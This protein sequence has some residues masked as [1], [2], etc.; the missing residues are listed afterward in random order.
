MTA[1]EAPPVAGERDLHLLLPPSPRRV[2]VIEGVD[3][4][5]SL[6]LAGHD[7]TSVDTTATWGTGF[8]AVVLVAPSRS[9]RSVPDLLDRAGSAAAGGSLLVVDRPRW[10]WPELLGR[11]RIE[12]R[13]M[14]PIS[15]RR[16]ERHLRRRHG[17]VRCF[18]TTPH[19]DR[20]RHLLEIPSRIDRARRTRLRTLW[21]ALWSDAGLPLRWFAGVLS[22]LPRRAVLGTAPTV[23]WATS[24][25]EP[26]IVDTFGNA[27][28]A[29]LGS[30][31][32]PVV[33][34]L[35]GD[36]GRD[37]SVLSPDPGWAPPAVAGLARE[38]DAL[39]VPDVVVAR[40]EV[41]GDRLVVG[42]LGGREATPA[43]EVR[44]AVA[45]GHIHARLPVTR[46][47]LRACSLA[48]GRIGATALLGP[49]DAELADTIVDR[50][51][52]HGDWCARNLRI[53]GSTIG[54]FDLEFADACGP[55]GLDIAWLLLRTNGSL[56]DL[57]DAYEAAAGRPVTMTDLRL[58]RSAL[59]QRYG[60]DAA[61]AAWTK[62]ADAGFLARLG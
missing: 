44:L 42:W 54:V 30:P 1:I 43:D 59:A 57:V 28:L 38:L 35:A 25:A 49:E 17:D 13:G 41:V 52:T 11:R 21:D 55:I 36:A 47:P 12:D 37:I 3:V 23:V 7:V 24:G 4:G 29:F 8:D 58:G 2:L 16:M 19:V 51:W 34:V 45:L 60:D 39:D 48:Q 9:G 40:H 33:T 50:G 22:R 18:V 27:P 26:L 53:D 62:L 20:L 10:S 61:S 6:R 31:S 32:S 14:R 5:E 56:T 15:A 46:L